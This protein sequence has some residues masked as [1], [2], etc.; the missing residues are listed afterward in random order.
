[1]AQHEEL[2][3]IIKIKKAADANE[4]LI[5]DTPSLTC[6]HNIIGFAVMSRISE[7]LGAAKQKKTAVLLLFFLGE[8]TIFQRIVETV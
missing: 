8:T 2:A 5:Q 1:M 3:M 7:N 6:N 4:I